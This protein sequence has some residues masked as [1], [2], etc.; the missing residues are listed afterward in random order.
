MLPLDFKLYAYWRTANC[1]GQE[2]QVST[3]HFRGMIVRNDKTVAE[4]GLT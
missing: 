1:V 3:L 4:T 2:M